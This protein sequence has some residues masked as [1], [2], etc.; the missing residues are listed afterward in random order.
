MESIFQE[1]KKP[2]PQPD[3]IKR[4]LRLTF[5]Q[6]KKLI[7]DSLLHTTKL[8]DDF[9]FFKIKTWVCTCKPSYGS[10]VG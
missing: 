10:L 5:H 9:P 4:L 7:N 8:L 1:L 3:L 6:R 2:R